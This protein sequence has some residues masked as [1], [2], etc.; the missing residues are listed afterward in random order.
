MAA[1]KRQGR[2][3][4]E[5]SDDIRIK[6]SQF[7]GPLDLLLHLINI[8][9]VD[10]Y[11]IPISEITSQYVA[12]LKQLKALDLEI[13]G[14]FIVMASTLMRIKSDWLLPSQEIDVEEEENEFVDPRK[15]LSDR[16]AEY[17][18]YKDISY[19][20]VQLKNERQNYFV[21]Q[22]SDLSEYQQTI[23]LEPNE[24]DLNDLVQAVFRVVRRQAALQTPQT[25]IQQ[26]VESI[27]DKIDNI[28][29]MFTQLKTNR[30]TF[31]QL[32]KEPS[33]F[34]IVNSF[35]AV[36]ELMKQQEI[37]VY[38]ESAFSDIEIMLRRQKES[39]EDEK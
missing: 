39:P 27:E 5:K 15:E 14:E 35:L 10:I 6:I 8:N 2:I 29:K 1:T 17:Q 32:I 25:S 13:A 12:Y 34:E 33:R 21:S 30:I 3:V 28:R 18:L 31:T 22:P 23:P 9:E 19:K 4:L 36:L 7:E 38:Q 11:D 26:E 37:F 24:V 20:L 16:L